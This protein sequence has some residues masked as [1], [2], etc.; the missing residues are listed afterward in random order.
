MQFCRSIPLVDNADSLLRV[1]VINSLPLP[2]MFVFD[3]ICALAME[4]KRTVHKAMT[5]EPAKS[6]YHHQQHQVIHSA[7]DVRKA[8]YYQ[9][10]YPAITDFHQSKVSSVNA[11]QYNYQPANQFELYQPISFTEVQQQLYQPHSAQFENVSPY[12]DISPHHGWYPGQDVISNVA[13]C[14]DAV[15][16]AVQQPTKHYIRDW[17]RNVE[18]NAHLQKTFEQIEKENSVKQRTI[19]KHP[20]Q[21]NLNWLAHQPPKKRMVWNNYYQVHGTADQSDPG[22][23]TNQQLF[24]G[25]PAVELTTCSE[26][27]LKPSHRPQSQLAVTNNALPGQHDNITKSE[28]E[29]NLQSAKAAV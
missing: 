12:K 17:L 2:L 3:R 15:Q 23:K 19:S 26:S 5:T 11:C 9:D 24:S 18:D 25:Q 4:P 22:H 20:E 28:A 27:S 6:F 8:T 10:P 14:A 21:F 16:N 13:H 1:I 29:N 7:N